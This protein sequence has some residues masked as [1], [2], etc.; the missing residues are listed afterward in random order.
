MAMHS[1]GK[2]LVVAGV[3]L[4]VIGIAFQVLARLPYIGRLPGDFYIKREHFTL[5]FPLTTCIII[6]LILMLISRFFGHK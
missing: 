3:L 1:I 5:Y 4:V 2:A 6:S